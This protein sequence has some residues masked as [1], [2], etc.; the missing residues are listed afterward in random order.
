MTKSKVDEDKC[1]TIGKRAR[2][3]EKLVELNQVELK[4]IRDSKEDL[5]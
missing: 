5:Q 1:E 3:I 4:I 2:E